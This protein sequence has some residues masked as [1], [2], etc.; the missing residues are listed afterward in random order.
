[1]AELKIVIRADRKRS[2]YSI[3]YADGE[4]QNADLIKRRDF[5]FRAI[6]VAN[7]SIWEKIVRSKFGLYGFAQADVN[8]TFPLDRFKRNIEII[9]QAYAC[10]R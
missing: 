10:A 6:V 3:P 7:A 4:A 5:L 8:T 2:C 1:V 9:R